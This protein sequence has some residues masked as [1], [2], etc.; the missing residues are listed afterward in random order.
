MEFMAARLS[1]SEKKPSTA[2]RE[3]GGG[4]GEA[5]RQGQRRQGHRAGSRRQRCSQAIIVR[6]VGR[7]QQSPITGHQL[8]APV[9]RPVTRV[10]MAGVLVR[11]LILPKAG[12]RKRSRASTC[13]R[14][15]RL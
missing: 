1:N 12:G 8:P 10:A 2:G 4:R 5:G 6:Q 7:P 3:G 13:S 11:L 9:M 15:A 14:R